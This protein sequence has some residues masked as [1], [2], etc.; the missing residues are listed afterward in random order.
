MENQ[1]GKVFEFNT[2]SNYET[3][4]LHIRETYIDI[5]FKITFH[6]SK[7]LQEDSTLKI[8]YVVEAVFVVQLRH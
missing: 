6:I 5:I 7:I 1:I 8:I 2:F 3:E 4:P